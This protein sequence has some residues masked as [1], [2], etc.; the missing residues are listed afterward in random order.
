MPRG[1]YNPDKKLLNLLREKSNSPY[2]VIEV[3]NAYF[4]GYSPKESKTELRTWVYGQLRT[5]IKHGYIRILNDVRGRNRTYMNTDKLVGTKNKL[6]EENTSIISVLK[7]RLENTKM[8]LLTCLGETEEYEALSTLY[9]D[10]K[11][12]LQSKFNQA[13]E[14][15]IKLVGKVRALESL[16]DELGQ[17]Q[18]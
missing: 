12:Q 1:I 9:P 13:K 15:N 18:L 3:R 5:L 10:I 17:Q 4:D 2:T 7:N 6:V 16:M 8:E 14:S 11:K